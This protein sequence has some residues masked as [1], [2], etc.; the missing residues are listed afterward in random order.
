MQILYTQSDLEKTVIPYKVMNVGTHC[1]VEFY[2][3][4]PFFMTIGLTPHTSSDAKNPGV[5]TT[6]EPYTGSRFP[7]PFG[8]TSGTLYVSAQPTAYT[9]VSSQIL[10]VPDVY[11]N[12]YPDSYSPITWSLVNGSAMFLSESKWWINQLFPANV[13]ISLTSPWGGTINLNSTY[14]VSLKI[15]KGFQGTISGSMTGN[16]QITI[17]Q[18]FTGDIIFTNSGTLVFE[19][20]DGCEVISTISSSAYG[21]EMILGDEVTIYGW[22]SDTINLSYTKFSM[23]PGSLLQW[24]AGG[25]N[26]NPSSCSI[27]VGAGGVIELNGANTFWYNSAIKIDQA[28]TWVDYGTYFVYCSVEVGN[29]AYFY[30]PYDH[31]KQNE[32]TYSTFSLEAGSQLDMHTVSNFKMNYSSITVKKGAFMF[33]Y[34]GPFKTYQLM[35]YSTTIV[36]EAAQ[37]ILGPSSYGYFTS[38]QG[39][40]K[41]GKGSYCL[42]NNPTN[43]ANGPFAFQGVINVGE[44]AYVTLNVGTN[45][46][47]WVN[48]PDLL[49]YVDYG[50]QSS[51]ISNAISS[52]PLVGGG[53][54][55]LTVTAN[56]T[57]KLANPHNKSHGV[58][59][60]DL[61]SLSG[62]SPTI[63][64]TVTTK[65]LSISTT[66][67]TLYSGSA[68]SS[69]QQVLIPIG[70]ETANNTGNLTSVPMALN[71]TVGGTSPSI[72]FVWSI[73]YND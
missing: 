48:V 16:S 30:P 37:L 58:I 21:N 7:V 49:R 43:T 26:F 65:D 35:Q 69:P 55:V 12:T 54:P 61:Q 14:P 4:S 13:P 38:W 60:I 68:L 32:I 27:K 17:G 66:E 3:Y 8:I 45:D 72:N 5:V 28:A 18:M 46:A 41:I 47:G 33:V 1:T 15:G 63:Q 51:S 42:I 64:F 11:Y 53:S 10:D 31:S 24:G 36:E 44:F 39:A 67:Y 40:I 25:Y 20:G 52:M 22:T 9:S 19:C 70:F 6:V 59:M 57:A 62:T 73:V 2:N 71:W 56:G 50:A 29:G 23:E 34:G